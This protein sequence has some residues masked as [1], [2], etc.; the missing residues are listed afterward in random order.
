MELVTRAF[1]SFHVLVGKSEKDETAVKAALFSK[2]LELSQYE[3]KVTKR[4][5]MD[6]TDLAEMGENF[7]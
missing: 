6:D 2:S 5:D 7:V 3:M 1:Q 4:K